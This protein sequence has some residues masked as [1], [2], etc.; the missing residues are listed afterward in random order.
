MPPTY[1]Y[2]DVKVLLL[3]SFF[4]LQNHSGA[5]HLIRNLNI[6]AFR[7]QSFREGSV[8]LRHLFTPLQHNIYASRE[9]SLYLNIMI[10]LDKPP[11]TFLF[12]DR[13]STAS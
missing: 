2:N 4:S 1:I 3:A 13:D 9:Q 5:I 7:E 12:S 6:Y 11:A 10:R 8:L